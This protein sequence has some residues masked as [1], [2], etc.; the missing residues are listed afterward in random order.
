MKA[1]Y[2]QLSDK[3]TADSSGRYHTEDI[4]AVWKQYAGS[5][6]VEPEE[7]WGLHCYRQLRAALFPHIDPGSDPG[8]YRE[9][10]ESLL[11]FFRKVYET[12]RKNCS[13]DP[14][15]DMVFL[16]DEKIEGEPYAGEYKKLRRLFDEMY[17]Y[18][19]M[20]IGA[21][22][23]PFN[24]LGH[25]SGVHYIAM[26]VGTQLKEAG[27]PVDLGLLS[28][29]AATHDIGK[30]GCRKHEEKR[31]P[32]LHYY[33]TDYCLNR[34][35]LPGVA[36]IAANHSTWDLELENLP[37]E[38]LLLIYSDFRNKSTRTDGNEIIHFYS[39]Q[40]AFDVILNKLDNVDEAKKHRYTKVYHKLKDF[41]DFMVERGVHTGIEDGAKEYPRACTEPLEPVIHETAFLAGDEIVDQIK[42]RAVEHNIRLMRLFSNAEEFGSLIEAARSETRWKNARTYLNILNEYSTYM[43]DEQKTMTLDFLYEMLP[44]HESDIREQ[45]ARV[46]GR[47]V[48]RY[49]MEYK[50]ELPDDIP[51]QD[52]NITNLMMF[53]R[54]IE[55]LL[56]PSYKYAEQHQKWIIANTDFF[57]R[58]V[59]DNCRPSC[60]HKYYEL[61]EPYFDR[62][63]NDELRVI[64]LLSIALHTRPSHCPDSYINKAVEFAR[65]NIGRFGI[66]VDLIALDVIGHFCG[67]E[68]AD[69]L[70]K[71][72]KLLGINGDD[73]SE[74]DLSAMFLDDL[75]IQTHWIIKAANIRAM[76]A[77]IKDG[78][79][80][81]RLL[82]IATHFVNLIKV[83][84][85][86]TVRK[87]AG[88]ALLTIIPQLTLDQRN[89]LVVELF[90]GLEIEDYQFSR[91]IPDY[92]GVV[93][94]YLSP[95]EIDE[96][97]LSLKKY[98]NAGNERSASAALGTLAVA[99]ENYGLYKGDEPT[100]Q[101][102]AR[103]QRMLG[104]LLK[105]FAYYKSA[106]S[107]EAFRSYGELFASDI[108]SLE[109]KAGIAS[110]SFKRILTIL[111]DSAE[112]DD[113]NFY[114]NTAVLNQLYRF[115]SEYQSDIGDFTSTPQKKVA[116]FPGTFDPFSLGHK[117]IAT[118]IRDMDYEVY[119]AI[120]EFSWSK[121]TLP[122]MLRKDILAMSIADEQGLYIFPNNISV[123]IANPEDLRVLRHIFEGRELYIAVGS[124][125][126]QNAS[127]YKKKPQPYSIHSFNHIVFEREEVE[128]QTEGEQY[129]VTGEVVELSLEK[130]YEDISSTRIRDNIDL[131]RDISSLLDPIVQNY[132]YDRNFYAREPAYKH[133]LQAMEMEIRRYEPGEIFDAGQIRERLREAGYDFAKIRDCLSHPDARTIVICTG[134][135]ERKVSAFATARRMRS[136]DLLREFSDSAVAA[137]IREEA[138]GGIALISAFYAEQTDIATLR[139]ILLTELLTALLEKDYVY[140]VYHPV[141]EAGMDPLTV[142]I[143]EKQGF[144]NISEDQAHP[145]YAVD[146]RDPIV[147]FRDVETV[148]KAPLNKNPRVQKA[149]DEAHRKLLETFR[150]IYPGK[151][152]ITFNTS[153]VHNKIAA[154]VAKENGVSLSPD[155]RRRRGPYLSVP[156]GKALSDVVVPNTVTKALKTEKYFKNDLSG[157]TIREMKDYQTLADQAKVLKSF[158]RPA[159][160]IDDLLH[161]GQRMRKID[162]TLREADVEVRKVIVGLLTGN[163]QDDM[164]VRGR[165]VEGAYFI[166]S[167][168]LWLNERDCYPFIG[169]DGIDGPEGDDEVSIN[170]M[171]PYT[172]FAFVGD[173]DPDK[174]Y[175]YSITCLENAL[176]ILKVLEQ[177]Y[178]RTFEKKLTLHRLGAVLNHP[179]R[180]LLG[181]G[182]GYDDQMAPSV[183]VENDIRWLKRLNLH[184]G[185]GGMS[186]E[187]NQ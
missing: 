93:I 119:L 52:E 165:D 43:S 34:L 81:S 46:M 73:L 161:S 91:F 90:N 7:G 8:K 122:H 121:K 68:I 169:G 187:T 149:I 24:T 64:E 180:P 14:T 15:R 108:L 38:S 86:V 186:G 56:N 31:V 42:S 30:Y 20:R 129:P 63:G 45:T 145:I 135:T 9:G 114:N 6:F 147:V 166:P 80:K 111:P 50:K 162:P 55:L 16:P 100:A 92:L 89:E 140:A 98:I 11:A 59:S 23:T 133:V 148:I 126:I 95:D 35:G 28:A 104:M 115:V 49:R 164:A 66:C 141:C 117:A 151:L 156:F 125:V 107:R 171:M 82:H 109:Q 138:S 47:I 144:V 146:M 44:H 153:A 65:A 184:R 175:L 97:V 4:V 168:S 139:Q 110:R 39:L 3:L 134:E 181:G 132:I 124:D 123:N 152:L 85:T 137:R 131:G 167:I 57:V 150:E 26:Y 17:I 176:S 105:G 70:E 172:S 154:L 143:L 142:R 158:A 120:D 67:E 185:P 12:E 87:N 96:T 33:Y 71:Q 94:L 21:D 60:R 18:E 62:A 72:Q 128:L 5:D 53:E 61:L 178:Q 10:R 88:E 155:P 183:Y 75:K 25:V 102:E 130:Y 22:L 179:R 170:L 159:I 78:T 58:S 36:R 99:V 163:A 77:S 76:L 29:A 103:R 79:D 118:T 37:V 160:L 2:E 182:L 101:T 173:N 41:E 113:L 157:F 112:D 116:F 32:Y 84:E 127:C 177:E 51:A 1:N 13:F 74:E 54:M 19:F 69:C 106:I 27:I 136:H 48:G 174:I 83:S 40:E